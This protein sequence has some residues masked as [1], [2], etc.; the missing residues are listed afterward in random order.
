M[1]NTDGTYYI[2]EGLDRYQS[3]NKMA[4]RTHI[5]STK[6]K[7]F[8][9]ITSSSLLHVI[10]FESVNS[11]ILSP[12]DRS[13]TCSHSN[14]ILQLSAQFHFLMSELSWGENILGGEFSLCLY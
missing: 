3:R 4:V 5:L 10:A 1:Y 12:K 9:K 11:S 6:T 13:L 7:V 8:T 14:L 2:P